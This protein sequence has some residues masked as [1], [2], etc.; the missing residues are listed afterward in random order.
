MQGRTKTVDLSCFLKKINLYQE[1]K[2]PLHFRRD[3][4]QD[5]TRRRPGSNRSL[6]ASHRLLLN[7]LDVLKF[8]HLYKEY[9]HVKTQELYI[10]C[11]NNSI[12]VISWRRCKLYT[13]SNHS[14]EIYHDAT[15]NATEKQN[16]IA[17]PQ[18]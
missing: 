16:C 14:N 6:T 13:M 1:C 17:E 7:I 4:S 12:H 9:M 2:C 15:C 8:L 10:A 3:P 11:F 5:C 18:N